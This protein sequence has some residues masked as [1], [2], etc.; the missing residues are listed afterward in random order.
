[1][2]TLFS[3]CTEKGA[4]RMV[5]ITSRRDSLMTLRFFQGMSYLGEISV[6]VQLRRELGIS[7]V[8]PIGGDPPFLLR[9]SEKNAHILAWFFGAF[10]TRE[11]A[12][13]WMAYEAQCID[14][15]RLDISEQGIGPRLQVKEIHEHHN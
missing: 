5:V 11:H 1:M 6:N 10:H 13:L 9:S 12:A 8:A 14:F 3:L 4:D 7:P 15:Y 2:R